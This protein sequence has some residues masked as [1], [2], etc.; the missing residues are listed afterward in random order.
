M[1]NLIHL[2]RVKLFALKQ[3]SLLT[4][5]MVTVVSKTS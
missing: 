2:T 4:H 5:K 1:Q 3:E